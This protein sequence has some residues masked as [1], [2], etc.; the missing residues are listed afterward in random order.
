MD[1]ILGYEKGTEK[2]NRVNYFVVLYSIR[3]PDH[4]ALKYHNSELKSYCCC[5]GE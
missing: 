3:A 5:V 4:D 2:H 1:N